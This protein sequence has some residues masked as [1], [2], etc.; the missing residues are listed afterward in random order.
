M[1]NDAMR[2]RAGGVKLSSIIFC[3]TVLVAGL[4]AGGRA[5]V[6]TGSNGSDGAFHPTTSININM[7]S[8]PSGIYQ[9]TSVNIPSGVIVTFTPNTN[10][11]P[12][13]WLMQGDVVISGTVSLDGQLGTDLVAGVGGPGGYRGGNAGA[14]ATS[15]QGPGGGGVGIGGK[16]GG[17][18]SYGTLGPSSSTCGSPGSIY[19]NN[20]LIPLMGGSGG[21]GFT[22]GLGGG[23][24]GGAILIASSGTIQLNGLISAEGSGVSSSGGGNYQGGGSGGAVR[25]VAS[26]INGAG[27]INT[28]GGG[29]GNGRVRFDTYLNSFAGSVNYAVFSQGSQFVVVPMAGS[30]TQ[31]T[32]TSVGGVPV[33]ASPT[34]ILARPDAVLS[35]LQSNPIS[36]VV[37]CSSIPLNTQITVTVTPVNGPPVTVTGYNTTGTQSSST[38]TV[39]ITMPRGGGFIS[40]SAATGS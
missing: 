26:T 30:G 15:G 22:R 39:S 7:A 1:K 36:I 13:V 25:L 24:G 11:T 31:L 29:G 17:N 21:G 23:G 4:P 14:N 12:V 6:N 5:Q 38:A 27:F 37:Q 10:N 28:S 8:R 33:S 3:A 16:D 2:R 18:A 9:Y 40:A 19:G 34:G 32:I 35:A 20:F